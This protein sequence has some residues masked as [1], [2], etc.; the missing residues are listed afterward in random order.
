MG[1]SYVFH[2]PVVASGSG[3]VKNLKG[4]RSCHFIR[5]SNMLWLRENVLENKLTSCII[6]FVLL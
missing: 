1:N 2:A 5:Q 3:Q 6:R 4:F